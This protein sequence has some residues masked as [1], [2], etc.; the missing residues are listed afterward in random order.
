MTTLTQ[1]GMRHADERYSPAMLRLAFQRDA[2]EG[3]PLGEKVLPTKFFSVSLNFIALAFHSALSYLD[4]SRTNFPGSPPCKSTLK[5][6][7]ETNSPAT[8]LCKRGV[9]GDFGFLGVGR[10]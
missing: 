4:C 10:A 5:D 1:L 9:R 7:E 6:T 8:P 3:L 2:T